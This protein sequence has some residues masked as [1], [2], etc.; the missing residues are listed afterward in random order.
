[1]EDKFI[2]NVISAGN[3]YAFLQVVG[4]DLVESF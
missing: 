4:L 1:M 3:V 2:R